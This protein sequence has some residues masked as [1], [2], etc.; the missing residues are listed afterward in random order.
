MN[1][2]N[3][4]EEPTLSNYFQAFIRAHTIPGADSGEVVLDVTPEE[5][6]ML[7]RSFLRILFH[8]FT[9]LRVLTVLR[10]LKRVLKTHATTGVKSLDVEFDVTSQECEML[11]RDF[12]QIMVGWAAGLPISR[13]HRHG[14]AFDVRQKP[15]HLQLV[16]ADKLGGEEE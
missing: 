12:I 7:G 1:G 3:I 5:C 11:G 16:P 2:N 8:W 14:I 15:S 4:T 6:E 10:F 13:Q 9:A